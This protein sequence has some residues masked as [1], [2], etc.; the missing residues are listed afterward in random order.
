MKRSDYDGDPEHIRSNGKVYHCA[1]CGCILDAFGT[2]PQADVADIV[3]MSAPVNC[4]KPTPT[5]RYQ[6]VQGRP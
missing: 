6:A 5:G 2:C 3:R 4:G 1:D